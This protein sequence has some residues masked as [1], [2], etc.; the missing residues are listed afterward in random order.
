[1]VPRRL[2]I[3]SALVAFSL[4]GDSMLYAV[5]PSEAAGLGLA[6]SAVGWVLSLNRWIRL[7]TNPIAGRIC[8]RW[9]WRWP[10]LIAVLVGATTTLA[11]AFVGGALWPLLSARCIWGLS[12]SFLRQGGHSAVLEVSTPETRGRSMGFFAGIFRIGSLVGMLAGGFL[13][14][15]I[16]FQPTLVL[17]GL[18]SGLGILIAGFDNW[19]GGGEK[20]PLL[21]GSERPRTFGP[22]RF[23][24]S[25]SWVS[26]GTGAFVT[27]FCTSG[28]VTATLGYY[29]LQLFSGLHVATLTGLLLSIRWIFGLAL[30]PAMGVISDRFGRLRTLVGGTGLGAV[31]L[32]TLAGA[33][34]IWIVA[35][36]VTVI[37]VAES[38]VSI[39]MD[40]AAGDLAARDGGPE[41]LGYYSTMLDMGAATG[42]LLG[43]Y[44]IAAGVALPTVYVAAAVLF[45]AGPVLY[46]M[47][48]RLV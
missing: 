18:I 13:T 36:G 8:A 29:L 22:R 42:P 28:L 19:L 5:L 30:S 37:W 35:V 43:Y 40:A 47:S 48:R 33:S 10:F 1:M 15:V 41:A 11:Y 17:F 23:L 39:S 34:A 44:L 6:A 7:L 20:A 27:H 2:V 24:G 45:T 31:G 9:G 14:D 4:L 26:M 38:A 16:G 3:T 25:A 32:L 12:W 46:Q 21:V